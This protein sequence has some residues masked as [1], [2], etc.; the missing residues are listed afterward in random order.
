[1]TS[2]NSS[3]LKTEVTLTDDNVIQEIDLQNLRGRSNAPGEL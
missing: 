3:F 2:Q 1:M